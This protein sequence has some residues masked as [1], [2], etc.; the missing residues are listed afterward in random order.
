[1]TTLYVGL[2]ETDEAVN[3]TV[4][5]LSKQ[6]EDEVQ[7]RLLQF[8]PK[9]QHTVPIADGDTSWRQR[10]SIDHAGETLAQRLTR[11]LHIRHTDAQRLAA[12]LHRGS[13]VVT[14]ET[15]EAAAASI[16]RLLRTAGARIVTTEEVAGRLTPLAS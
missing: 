11:R 13:L 7:W 5:K 15:T 2:L 16:R 12:G 10:A 4:D 14:V 9:V 1:M 3:E 6:A 8:E